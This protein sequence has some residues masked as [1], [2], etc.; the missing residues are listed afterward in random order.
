MVEI[1]L[2]LLHNPPRY[3]LSKDLEEIVG[4]KT[5]SRSQI[6]TALWEYIKVN[7]L[8]DKENREVIHCDDRFAR[9]FGADRIQMGHINMN[10]KV[11]I[12]QCDPIVIRHIVK[13][14]GLPEESL[15]GFDIEVDI[16]F[17]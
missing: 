1:A 13:F 7:Q 8:Q 5:G 10:L 14:S 3:K 4:F 15:Q 2:Q 9:L 6:L 17:V 16:E 12:S 11:L